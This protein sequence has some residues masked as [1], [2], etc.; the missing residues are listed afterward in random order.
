M[1]GSNKWTETMLKKHW[2]VVVLLVIIFAL[3]KLIN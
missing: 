2:W 1:W 3:G